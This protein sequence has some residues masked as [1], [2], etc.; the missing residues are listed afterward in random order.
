MQKYKHF[1]SVSNF[2][3]ANLQIFFYAV[4]IIVENFL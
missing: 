3:R 1:D 4:N 2:E